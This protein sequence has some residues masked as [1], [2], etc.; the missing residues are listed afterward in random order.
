MQ[1]FNRYIPP[2]YD[3]KAHA[4]LNSYQ[5][6]K[7]ALGKRAKDIDKGVLVVRF[8]L[9]FNIWCDH[10]NNHIGAGVRYNAQKR[11]VG[12]YY[13]TPIF[14]FRCKC[15]LCSGWFEIQTDPQNAA[16][17][18]TEGAR[19]KDEDWNPEE[20]G[21][22]AIH[23]TEKPS[24]SEPPADPFAHIEKT[25]EQV[26]Q[27]ASKQSR[28]TELTEHSAR[29]SADPYAVSAALRRRFRKEKRAALEKQA[30]DD[31]VRRRY[32]LDDDIDLGDDGD[33]EGGREMWETARENMGLPVGPPTPGG[34]ASSSTAPPAAI[35]VSKAELSA[36]I[37]R[38]T[39]RR[40]DPFDDFETTFA[41]PRARGRIEVGGSAPERTVRVATK[42]VA[43]PTPTAIGGLL[44]GYESD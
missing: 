18:V 40:Y 13:S 19:K 4:T 30:R 34:A 3:P 16:Y 5:G 2:D 23:D 11:K 20:N 25:V 14:A 33:V 7:H 12:N 38:N 24:A 36:L 39:K 26:T 9:P 27:A 6:K 21:G 1:G 43:T 32:G 41:T 15:H 17:V 37:R 35:A 8:E 44:A 22:Y 29:L 42:E 31:G 28:L 10:C